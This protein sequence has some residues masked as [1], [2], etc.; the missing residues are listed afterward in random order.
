M[1]RIGF[2]R[3][4][5]LTQNLYCC[6]MIC[7]DVVVVWTL[8]IESHIVMLLSTRL[9]MPV[10]GQ[11]HKAGELELTYIM[12]LKIVKKLQNVDASKCLRT[13]VGTHYKSNQVG[14]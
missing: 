7:V 1:N 10:G 5:N 6:I 14:T 13:Q 3:T 8:S 12:V 4:T 11:I 9:F 2:I